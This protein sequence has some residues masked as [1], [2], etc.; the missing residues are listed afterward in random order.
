[1]KLSLF[2][3]HL[4]EKFIA[5]F[6]SEKRDESK[7]LVF[8]RKTNNIEFTLFKN[9][10]KYIDSKN[11]LV[12][13][14]VKVIPARLLGK[15]A[16]G[17]KVEVLLLK[18]KDNFKWEAIYK[19]SKPLKTGDEIFFNN[20]K[21]KVYKD[22]HVEF[23]TEVTFDFLEEN[24]DSHMPL[25]PYLKRAD[26]DIDRE[27]YQTVYS[28][29]M[30]RG[31]VAAP[32]AGLHFTNEI[33]SKLKNKGIEIVEITLYVGIGTFAPIRKENIKEH[34]MHC[35]TY[36]IPPQ[37]A[38]KINKAIA[39]GKKIVAVGTTSVRAL[40]DNFQRFKTIKLGNFSTDI[41]IYPGFRFNVVD[42]LITNFHLPKS[43]LLMLV[44]A[45]AGRE[46]ILNCYEKAKENNFRFFSYG[47]SML[48]L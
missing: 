13:N 37:S 22:N 35:E 45:F 46:N 33:L 27:R 3:Y 8:N 31:A 16:T 14:N 2:D 6:P 32:T 24:T 43:T 34:K 1:M 10:V 44:S 41:F 5:K 48:I 36:E 17:G 40:E 23:N 4:P 20:F 25:P 29:S 39:E 7:L 15:K 12:I 38:Q 9:I 11:I 19:S 42:K 47:D 26:T 18:N 30:K 21:C 28:S